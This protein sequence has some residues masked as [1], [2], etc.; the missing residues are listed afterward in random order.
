M[1]AIQERRM[2]R[3]YS[4][5]PL[6]TAR[7]FQATI[8]VMATLLTL[9]TGAT[10]AAADGWA[11]AVIDAMKSERGAAPKRGVRVASIARDVD[12]SDASPRASRS[13]RKASIADRE[14]DRP[15]QRRKRVA[16]LNRDDS[17]DTGSRRRRSL[18]GG[19]VDWTASSGC[20]N[21][22]LKSV[23]GSLAS[24]YGQLRVNSTCRSRSHNANVG[25]AS[26]SYHLTGDA[27]DFRVFSNVS[28]VYASLRSNGDVGGL[29]HY[30]GGL[31]H[32]DTGP[33][34]SW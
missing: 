30:G 28:A 14:E 1:D 2:F 29:K 31:F 6:R 20:L 32:I 25:G 24:N 27:A 19:S 21:G 34:R 10:I 17:G 5:R 22:T 13:K 33:R 15:Q 3:G 12:V 4:S 11:D 16:S 8:A 7:L 26:K 9:T 18:S 23:L